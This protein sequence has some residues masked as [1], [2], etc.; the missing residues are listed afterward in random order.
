MEDCGIKPEVLEEI[1]EI[2]VR[3]DISKVILFG[4]RAHGDYCE[5]SDIIVV[6]PEMVDRVPNAIKI[7]ADAR[8]YRISAEIFA[9]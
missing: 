2:A 8:V 6:K 1:K 7:S 9:I 4:S 3:N 5:T